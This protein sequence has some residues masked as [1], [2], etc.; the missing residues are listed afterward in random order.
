MSTGGNTLRENFIFGEI[1]DD[2]IK[3]IFEFTGYFRADNAK[4]LCDFGELLGKQVSA[5]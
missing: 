5:Y 4:Q 2:L 3:K 1:T